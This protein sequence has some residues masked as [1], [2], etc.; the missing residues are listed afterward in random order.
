MRPWDRPAWARRALLAALCA[1]LGSC[2]SLV[3]RSNRFMF[4][5][6]DGIDC[7]LLRP[8][9]HVYTNVVPSFLRTAVSNVFDNLGELDTILNDLLQGK[10]GQA[11]NDTAR[12]AVNTTLGLGGLLDVA[13]G[14]ELERHEEDFG[15][16]LG[17]WGAPPGPYLVL[18]LFGPSSVRDA[19]MIPF[20]IVTNPLT[21]VDRRTVRTSAQVLNAV[22]QRSRR[23]GDLRRRDESAADRYLFTREAYLQRRAFQVQDGAPADEESEEELEKLLEEA[24]GP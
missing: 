22:D 1:T 2:A 8:A 3:E 9:S 16:T 23:S 11:G 15:Q 18:P 4:G 14:M 7:A 24:Q 10:L 13:Q 5:L 20:S 19:A 6:N 12:F 17:V 21:W